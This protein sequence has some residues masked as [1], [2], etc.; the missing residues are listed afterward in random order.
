MSRPRKYPPELLDRGAR[1]VFESGRPIAHVARDL[2]VPSETLRKYV[3]QVEADEGRRPDLPT[4]E[5]REE[6]K[7]AAQG[8][9]RAAARERDP[10]GR[11]GVFRDRARRRPT[12][13]SRFIDEH[14]GRFG[15]EPICRTLGVSASAYYQ[16]AT[17]ARSA[18]A[19]EDERLLEQ[20]ERV[21]AANYH[22][23]GY[24]RT[25]LAL[26]RDGIAGRPRPRQAADARPRHPGRQAARQAVAHHD[27]RPGRAC[28]RPTAS[29]ATSPPRARTGCGWRTSAI[30]AAGKASCSSPS[31]STSD[32]AGSSAGSWPATCAPTWC[33]TRC[34]WRSR[35]AAPA[36]TSSS[37]TTP[38]P[39]ANPDST[40]PRNSCPCGE[41]IE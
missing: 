22:C 4:S 25:W 18:R 20:I 17:G 29:T 41:P 39:A 10:Q 9:L 30:C 34:G 12:E 33:S 2:G 27:R 7:R 19:V 1:L 3:R 26:R 13:V 8:E 23:Y 37:C 32:R 15:V 28:G 14:R 16:R 31:S 11:V 21:H 5:E 38:M 24:R 36:P 35:A 40:G 6:I